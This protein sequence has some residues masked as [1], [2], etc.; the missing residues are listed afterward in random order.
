MVT[1][2]LGGVQCS[3]L[4][5]NFVSYVKDSGS[6]AVVMWHIQGQRLHNL[7]NSAVAELL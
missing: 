1:C 4:D 6:C 3:R 2:G 7:F 5:L